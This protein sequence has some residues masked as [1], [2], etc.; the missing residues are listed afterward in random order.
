MKI[1]LLRSQLVISPVSFSNAA[2]GVARY[3]KQ[4][5]DSAQRYRERLFIQLTELLNGAEIRPRHSGV[6]NQSS[7]GWSPSAGDAAFRTDL[8]GRTTRKSF[9]PPSFIL[10]V[11]P[12]FYF[13]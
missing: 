8:S 9:K 5:A 1:V 4:S 10:R 12:A 7:K 2:I 11:I 6:T 13:F 3:T